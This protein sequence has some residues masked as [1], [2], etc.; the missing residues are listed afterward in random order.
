ME[1]GLSSRLSAVAAGKPSGQTSASMKRLLCQPH[2]RPSL[3]L[4]YILRCRQ[5]LDARFRMAAELRCRSWFTGACYFAWENALHAVLP[6][7]LLP[8]HK[9]FRLSAAGAE[10]ALAP[11]RQG[12]FVVTLRPQTLPGGRGC[13]RRSQRTASA[14][15]APTSLPT[16]RS[17]RIG[18]R[19][20]CR[21][22]RLLPKCSS[23]AG[24]TTCTV[25]RQDRADPVATPCLQP[26]QPV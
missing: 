5:R 4:Q 20:G 25:E 15:S 16:K 14:W 22:V 7:G 12:F 9:C 21:L 8:T 10:P 18:S 11:T 6:A 1:A 19:R 23:A 3:P 24:C 2:H 13:V 26:R 17:R